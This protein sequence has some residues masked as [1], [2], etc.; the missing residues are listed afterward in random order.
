[1]IDVATLL[2]LLALADG[3]LA[4]ALAATATG[5]GS[6]GMPAWILA[7]AARALAFALLAA[8]VQPAGG[9]LAVS[10]GLLALSLTL[11]GHALLAFAGRGLPAW[12]HTGA[13]A[14]VVAPFALLQGEPGRL[15]VFGGLV[16]GT[17]AA[18]LALLAPQV[19]R[20]RAAAPRRLLC[21]CFAVAALAFVVR[22]L[23]SLFAAD[24][25][26]AFRAPQAP[27]SATLLAAA[28]ADLLASFAFLAMHKARGDAEALR[29]ATM[30]PL[31][32]TYNRRTFQEIA[33]R[34]LSRARRFGQPLSIILL[35]VDHFGAVNEAHGP[36]AADALLQRV[37]DVVRSALRREDMVARFGGEEFAVLLPEVPGPGAVVVAGRIRTAVEQEPLAAAGTAVAVTVSAGVAARLDEGPESVGK[38]LE[39]AEEAL[40]LAKRRGRNRVVALSLGRSL[41]A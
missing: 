36:E 38:L 20:T 13:I 14:A 8:G 28:A 2:A 37:A 17:L 4:A 30:D 5:P 15:V 33:A 3:L 10:A 1:M 18:L 11:Q 19:Q 23:A 6:D 24:P 16:F 25:L 7:L 40:A 9:A 22:A 35:D 29:L 41:A 27:Q 12:V 32:G 21:A 31:T 26:L 39:R 34:E